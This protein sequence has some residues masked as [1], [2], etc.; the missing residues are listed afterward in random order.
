MDVVSTIDQAHRESARGTVK[1][2]FP[3][4]EDEVVD[5]VLEANGSDLGRM[6]EA[7]LEIAGGS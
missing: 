3:Q 6:I 5:M 4:V 1:Q 2:M 7:M